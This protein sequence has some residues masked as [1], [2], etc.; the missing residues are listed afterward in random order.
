MAR[1]PLRPPE[2]ILTRNAQDVPRHHVV[3][4]V[5]VFFTTFFGVNG[6]HREN[7][8]ILVDSE[9][10]TGRSVPQ[11]L[12]DALIVHLGNSLALL[13]P[14]PALLAPGGGAGAAALPVLPVEPGEDL[15][16]DH[17]RCVGAGDVERTAKTR[18]PR[19]CACEKQRP[20]VA[21]GS[22]QDLLVQPGSS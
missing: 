20:L 21:S 17:V 6:H 5:S 14:P 1:G 3:E 7:A 22:F 12:V 4:N 8:A 9:W 15:P 13:V 18:R 10:T 2:D 19:V 16:G 11:T